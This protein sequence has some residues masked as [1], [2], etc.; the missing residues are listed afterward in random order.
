MRTTVTIDDAL[1][2]RA[3]ALTGVK[4]KAALLRLGV[5]TL[6]RVESGRRLIALGGHD[7]DAQGPPRR[8]SEPDQ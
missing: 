1:F 7:P 5:E 8:R 2:E 4:E 6:V 3:V